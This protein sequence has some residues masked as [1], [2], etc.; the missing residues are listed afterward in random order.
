MKY[1]KK[2]PPKPLLAVV[3]VC[4]LSA[5]A[6]TVEPPTTVSDFCLNDQRISVS[7]GVAPDPENKFDTEET[8]LQVLEHN[9]VYDTLCPSSAS[10]P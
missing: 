10:E 9:E 8:T 6:Q 2:Y 4:I 7:V 3:S 5:C 1:V